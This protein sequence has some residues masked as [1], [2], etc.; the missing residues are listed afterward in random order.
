VGGEAAMSA[1]SQ[2]DFLSLLFPSLRRW[3]L[4]VTIIETDA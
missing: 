3:H 2:P 1:L 4:I